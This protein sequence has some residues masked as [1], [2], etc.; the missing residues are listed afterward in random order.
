MKNDNKTLSDVTRQ[1]SVNKANKF[2]ASLMP[3]AP[4]SRPEVVQETKSAETQPD[5]GEVPEAVAAPVPAVAETP[6]APVVQKTERARRS[7]GFTVEEI[8]NTP[9]GEGNV[10]TKMVRVTDDHHELLR[11]MAFKYRKNMNVIVHNL[12]GLLDQAYQK[13]QKGDQSNV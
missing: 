10:Y 1:T 13:E 9:A 4:K 3:T 5:K 12:I 2:A 6:V 8:V 7:G 11:L